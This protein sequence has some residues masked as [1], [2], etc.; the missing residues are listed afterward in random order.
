MARWPPGLSYA[1][2]VVPLP[3]LDLG[4]RRIGRVLG[5]P[6][7][8]PH[9]IPEVG[10]VGMGQVVLK[11]A[12]LGAIDQVPL[13]LGERHRTERLAGLHEFREAESRYQVG[14]EGRPDGG[15]VATGMMD[16]QC[17]QA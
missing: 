2:Q 9:L 1:A 3:D 7:L 14:H 10:G 12:L 4:H 13:P 6:G 5:R 16:R 17:S 11:P 15:A 8:P